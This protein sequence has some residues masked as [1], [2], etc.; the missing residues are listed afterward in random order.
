[1][2]QDTFFWDLGTGIGFRLDWIGSAIPLTLVYGWPLNHQEDVV[3]VRS[4]H[5]LVLL[6]T[7]PDE[8]RLVLHQ[9][10]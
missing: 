7:D 4:D 5:D 10:K 8:A 2:P 3:L 9:K 1:M 6:R